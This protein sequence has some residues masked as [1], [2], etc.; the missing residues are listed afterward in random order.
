[1]NYQYF[2]QLLT[3]YPQNYKISG[4]F[5]RPH[6]INFDHKLL[7]YGQIWAFYAQIGLIFTNLWPFMAINARNQRF[8][9]VY[10]SIRIFRIIFIFGRNLSFLGEFSNISAKLASFCP[11]FHKNRAFFQKILTF[12]DIFKAIIAL[13]IA[14]NSSKIA[15]LGH[16]QLK[17]SHFRAILGHFCPKM[18]KISPKFRD[19][20]VGRYPRFAKK[21]QKSACQ[22]CKF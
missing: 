22:P 15:I 1:M 6:I 18:S 2:Y 16:F 8:F 19:V 5:H 13:K 17:N 20:I 3:N 4:L 14:Q 11:I 9:S 7:I 21:H 10:T 12:F